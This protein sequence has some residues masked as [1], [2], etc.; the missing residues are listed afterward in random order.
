MGIVFIPVS[1]VRAENETNLLID[2]MVTFAGTDQG[3]VPIDPTLM[4]AAQDGPFDA[5]GTRFVQEVDGFEFVST[6]KADFLQDLA[7]SIWGRVTEMP[8]HVD[9]QTEPEN[10]LS[11]VP[12]HTDPGDA[13]LPPIREDADMYVLG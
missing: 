10:P 1:G 4:S 11:H 6:D 3:F 13:D 8:W 7:I 5:G 12:L 9:S 2:D